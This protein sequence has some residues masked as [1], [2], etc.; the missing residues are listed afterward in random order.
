MSSTKVRYP[1]DDYDTKYPY[2]HIPS[3]Q[4]IYYALSRGPAFFGTWTGTFHRASAFA[5]PVYSQ[6][7][8]LKDVLLD[9]IQQRCVD[10]E[11]KTSPENRLVLKVN[12]LTQTCK[13]T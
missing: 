11:A 7:T 8:W 6:H 3:E 13:F 5:L 9:L 10:Q 4:W 1:A 12:T 2:K